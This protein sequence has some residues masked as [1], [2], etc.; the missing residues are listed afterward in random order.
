[1]CVPVWTIDRWLLIGM[2]SNWRKAASAQTDSPELASWFLLR[3]AG[4]LSSKAEWKEADATYQEAI[5]TAANTRIAV[6]VQLLRAWALSYQ[7]RRS[8]P[9]AEKYFSQALA[10]C[11]QDLYAATLLNDLGILSR[12]R[13]DVAGAEKNHQKALGIAQPL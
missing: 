4:L 12:L 6:R 5:R 1:M 10:L 8:W 7:Q 13:G 2:A 9:D 11:S 3:A